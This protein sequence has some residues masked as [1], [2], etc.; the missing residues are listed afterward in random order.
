MSSVIYTDYSDPQWGRVVFLTDE[1]S[2]DAYSIRVRTEWKPDPEVGLAITLLKKNIKREGGDGAGDVLDLGANIG[3][4]CMPTCLATENRFLAF[5][6]LP[7]NAKLLQLAINANG[8]HRR[9]SL[10][11]LA[12]WDSDTTLKFSGSSAYGV[13][14][15]HGSINVP[16]RSLDSLLDDGL[17]SSLAL[18]KMDIE[19][20]ELRAINGGMRC[21]EKYHPDIIFEAN[22]AHCISNG[23]F[24]QDIIR[25]LEILGRYVSR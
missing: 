15:E 2:H 6:A 11:K 17:L 23:Y 4:W 20:C 24:P 14:D 19:G 21:L 22:G 18:I 7:S 12:I 16:A 1:E 13:V 3:T 5:E 10:H 8:L 9:L 25:T